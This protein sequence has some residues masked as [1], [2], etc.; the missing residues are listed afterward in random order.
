MVSGMSF[1]W[2][3]AGPLRTTVLV[4]ILSTLGSPG[5]AQD[6]REEVRKGRTL[7]ADEAGELERH[8]ANG[9]DD[10]AVRARLLGYHARHPRRER[11]RQRAHLLWFLRNLPHSEVLADHAGQIL[12]VFDPE[13]YV[14]VKAVWLGLIG[15][16]PANTRFLRHAS[17]FLALP[18]PHLAVRLLERGEALEPADPHW[19]RELGQLRWREARNPFSGSDPEGAAR[20]LADFERSFRLSPPAVRAALMPEIAMTAFAAGD[21]DKAR[22]HAE[23]MLN[24]L[25][26]DPRHAIRNRH[27]ANLVLGRVGLAENDL[28]EARTRLLAAGDIQG[29]PTLRSFGPDM[30]LAKALLERGET[31]TVL[32]YLELC[33]GFW[34]NGRERLR[35][36]IV[37]IEA[38][39]TPD[40]RRNLRF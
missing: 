39:R 9:R 7:T 5:F 11:G 24:A 8:L 36:W 10:P 25:P 34:E 38:G 26:R 17:G 14:E 13:G 31:G 30:S 15:N 3:S 28:E 21:H 22:R 12:P 1:A 2:R 32:R 18:E 27:V 20:A 4:G 19:A 6:L 33:L 37:L 16:E 23:T 35:D 40:F 29:S